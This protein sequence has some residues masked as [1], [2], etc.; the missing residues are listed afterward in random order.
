MSDSIIQITKGKKEFKR[1]LIAESANRQQIC[2]NYFGLYGAKPGPNLL[3]DA[4]VHGNEVVGVEVIRKIVERINP[5]TLSGNLFAIPILN[6]MAF[7]SEE[8]WDPYDRQDMNRIF[9]GDPDGTL[10]E[11]MAYFF[12]ERILSMADYVVD[13]HSAEFPDEMLPHI[14]VRIDN[15]SDDYWLLVH[16]SGIEVIWR[17]PSVAGMLQ[18]EANRNGIPCITIEIG[19][20]DLVTEKNV[21]VGIKAI[22]N[23]MN[24]LGMIDGEAM[25]PS[26]QISLASNEEWIRAHIGGIYKPDIELGALIE[27]GQKIGDILD[28]TSFEMDNIISPIK[29]FI[30]GITHRSIV[31]SGTRLAMLVNFDLGNLSRHLIDV[32]SLPN[33]RFVENR[34]LNMLNLD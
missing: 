21:E 18:T 6:P 25:V 9:P 5:K 4:A 24:V 8:R 3:L 34:F 11:R 19:A 23:I 17:G 22:E 13:L 15:P 20:A 27:K 29:G 2:L 16:A 33:V 10:T 31:R 28:P 32:P 1:F 30:T 14:R 12:F 26:Q 7:I